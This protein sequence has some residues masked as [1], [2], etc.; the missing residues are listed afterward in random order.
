MN[1]GAARELHLAFEV[2]DAAR[3]DLDYEPLRV[4]RPVEQRAVAFAP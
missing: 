2:H 1:D 3:V 4:R